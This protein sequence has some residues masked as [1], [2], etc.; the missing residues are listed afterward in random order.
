M[1]IFFV[2]SFTRRKKK[3]KRL[4]QPRLLLRSID[5]IGDNK[6]KRYTV[7][8]ERF[9]RKERKRQA[10][11]DRNKRRILISDHVERWNR[12]TPN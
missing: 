11:K 6:K 10:N 4:E 9:A 2:S 12:V 7:N 5:K 3:P 1:K 8:V